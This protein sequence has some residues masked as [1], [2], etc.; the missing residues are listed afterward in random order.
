MSKHK[1]EDTSA[2]TMTKSQRDPIVRVWTAS[3]DENAKRGG[4]LVKA[5]VAQARKSLEAS[6][7]VTSADAHAL[8]AEAAR[9]LGWKKDK[10]GKW[11]SRAHE[12]KAFL[13]ARGSLESAITQC[14][15]T[16]GAC[17]WN[18]ALMLAKG[19]AKGKSISAAIR[20]VKDA[21][22]DA[23]PADKAEACKR[24]ASRI[25]YVLE[26]PHLPREFKATLRQACADAGIKV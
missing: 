8:S 4:Q 2:P 16:L 15:K 5:I 23:P 21:G 24:A 13:N 11:N 7:V 22:S 19:I 14:E 26:L 3:V 20:A 12:I 1:A 9:V 6:Y 10:H 17:G 25:K 18:H